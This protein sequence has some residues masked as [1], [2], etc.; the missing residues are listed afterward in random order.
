MPPSKPKSPLDKPSS[1]H[2]RRPSNTRRSSSEKSATKS[3]KH[4][5]KPTSSSSKTKD[6]M[7]DLAPGA[8]APSHPDASDTERETGGSSDS[9]RSQ[10]FEGPQ[11][12][13]GDIPHLEAEDAGTSKERESEG[14]HGDSDTAKHV[15]R[16][17]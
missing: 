9:P 4:G 8:K 15:A 17:G 14:R 16:G 3:S 11:S 2:S 7:S 6:P 10:N 5:I 12:S 1:S 13:R